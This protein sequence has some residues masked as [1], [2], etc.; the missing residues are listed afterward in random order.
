MPKPLH[1]ILRRTSELGDAERQAVVQVCTAAHQHDFSELF[2]FLPPEG[3]HVLGYIGDQLAGHAVVTT[4]WLQ[5]EHGL[6][7]RTA[8]VDAVATE[9]TYQRLGVGSA[10]L[11]ALAEAIGDYDIA[12]LETDRESFYDRLGWEEWRGP[13]AG[14]SD[15][16]L[17]PTPQQTGIMILRLPRTPELALDGL[18]TIECQGVRIW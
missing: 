1:I 6:L 14:R 10:V 17:V 3:L 7:L 2:G 18:L 4:R 11:R 13:T 12:C 8:Y 9:P 16:G 15:E 5:F